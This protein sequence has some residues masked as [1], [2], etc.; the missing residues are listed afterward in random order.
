M[1]VLARASDLRYPIYHFASPT[2]LIE[3]GDYSIALSS[4]LS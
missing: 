2:R 4:P 1:G 3:E